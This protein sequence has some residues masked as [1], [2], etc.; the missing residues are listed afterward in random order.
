MY[1][2]SLGV[3]HRHHRKF[4]VSHKSPMAGSMPLSPRIPPAAP[5]SRPTAS[6]IKDFDIIKP[7]SKGAFGSVFLAKKRTTGDYYAI[8]V[9][10]KVGHD[11]QEPNHQRQ[12]G[13][14]DPHDAEPVAVRGQALLYVPERRV[15]VPRDGVFA[16]WRLR[17]VVQGARRVVRGVG[18]PVH[19][20]GGDW[21]AAPALEGRRASR[22]QA[23]QSA[24]R[25][26]GATSS[27]RTLVSPRSVCWVVRRARLRW[28]LLRARR[29]ARLRARVSAPT[30]TAG[31][32]RARRRRLRPKRGT[33]RCRRPPGRRRATRRLRSRP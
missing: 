13:A 9:L 10:K 14:Y 15:P 21:A 33:R 2:E 29:A 17:L 5:S 23:G 30:R 1:G 20:R 19:R 32:C 18:A 22:S 24:H 16:G 8:K 4:S 11:R 12:G 27:L 25:P 6:S 3:S 31:R 26:K 7:I 28:R